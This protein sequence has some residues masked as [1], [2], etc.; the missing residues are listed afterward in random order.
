MQYAVPPPE[1]PT[2]AVAN[3]EERYPVHRIYCVGRNYAEHAREMGADE[4]E[5]PFFFTKPADPVVPD[6]ATVPYPP[7]TG[8][9]HHEI[10][11]V[12]AIGRITSFSMHSAST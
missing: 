10:E 7:A 3:S 8:S 6:G 9:F 1:L 11:L 12:V 5:P 2:V 4:R